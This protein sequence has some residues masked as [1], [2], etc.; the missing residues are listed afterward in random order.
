ME[1]SGPFQF[2]AGTPDGVAAA[3]SAI[4]RELEERPNH[5]LLA[6]DV[7]S[8]FRSL[9]RAALHRTLEQERSA[10][11]AAAACWYHEPAPK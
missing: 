8:V 2:G 7:S 9:D 10:L 4:T 5:V 6:M 3:Y 1:C 11:A